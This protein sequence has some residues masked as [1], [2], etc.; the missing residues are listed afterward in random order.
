MP[1]ASSVIEVPS[2]SKGLGGVG[3]GQEEAVSRTGANPGSGSPA[4][5][6]ARLLKNERRSTEPQMLG[7]NSVSPRARCSKKRNYRRSVNRVP[8]PRAPAEVPQRTISGWLLD[9]LANRRV[10]LQCRASAF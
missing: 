7:F 5:P 10:A 4:T 1:A 8:H 9:R 3:G 6:A 2:S